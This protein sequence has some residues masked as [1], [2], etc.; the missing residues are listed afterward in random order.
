M[1]YERQGIVTDIVDIDPAVVRLAREYFGFNNSGSVYIEDARYFLQ[2]TTSRYDYL[3]LDVFNGDSTP[4]HVLSLEAFELM[5]QRLT[6]N[7]VVAINLVASLKQ[8]NEMTVA[9]L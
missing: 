3:L 2:R 8:R 4:G 7:G 9:I 6:E 1:W 5:R